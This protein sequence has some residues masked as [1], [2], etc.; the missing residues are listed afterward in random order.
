MRAIYALPL[1][2]TLAQDEENQAKADNAGKEEGRSLLAKLKPL[3]SH[4]QPTCPINPIAV[5]LADQLSRSSFK[6]CENAPV[7]VGH[8]ASNKIDMN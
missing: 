6:D 2:A 8:T 4:H 7:E 5:A 1:L 3:P